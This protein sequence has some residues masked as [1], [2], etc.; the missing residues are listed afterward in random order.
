MIKVHKN[1]HTKFD[2]K[3]FA[4]Y[5]EKIIKLFDVCYKIKLEEILMNMLYL[6]NYNVKNMS[7][8][9]HQNYHSCMDNIRKFVSTVLKLKS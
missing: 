7:F 9:F 2:N 5:I 6:T 8:A 3:T 4:Y 1:N